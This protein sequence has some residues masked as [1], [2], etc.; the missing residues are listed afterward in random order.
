MIK[1]ITIL[2]HNQGLIH[3]F[4]FDENK[5]DVELISDFFNEVHDKYGLY[6]RESECSW[7][8]SEEIVI[9]IH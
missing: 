7:M 5:F 8:F 6:L 3:I 9:K 2:D 4:D 1:K